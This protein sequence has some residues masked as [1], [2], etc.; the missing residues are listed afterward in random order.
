MLPNLKF[1]LK[2][3][4]VIAMITRP[5]WALSGFFFAHSCCPKWVGVG[6]SATFWLGK[7]AD[8]NSIVIYTFVIVAMEEGNM[9]NCFWILATIS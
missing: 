7:E 9:E 3:D 2:I 1:T 8:I 4:L 5:L 6:G